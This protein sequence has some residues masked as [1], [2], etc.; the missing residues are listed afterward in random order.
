[1]Q[2]RKQPI[3]APLFKPTPWYKLTTWS[4]GRITYN[5]KYALIPLFFFLA[6]TLLNSIQLSV[7]MIGPHCKIILY[8]AVYK[9][10]L[11]IFTMSLCGFV[12]V[13]F[14]FICWVKKND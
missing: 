13:I 9:F 4:D 3:H 11:L 6:F 1:M 14:I 10:Y 12:I 8:F 7:Q 2:L 5:L